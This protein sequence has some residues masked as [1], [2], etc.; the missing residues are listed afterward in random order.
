MN[1]RTSARLAWGGSLLA[2]AALALVLPLAVP[3]PWAVLAVLAVAAGLFLAADRTGKPDRATPAP[4]STQEKPAAATEPAALAPAPLPPVPPPQ[5]DL[6]GPRVRALED[7]SWSLHKAVITRIRSL[8]TP[9]SNSLLGIKNDL[10]GLLAKSGQLE[11]SF[12]NDTQG[13]HQTVARFEAQSATIRTF[14]GEMDRSV[15]QFELSSQE[16]GARLG[17]IAQAIQQI[18]DVAE[19]IKVLSINASI[20]AA[21]AGQ[22][23]AGFKVISQEVRRLAEDTNQF[24]DQADLTISEAIAEIQAQFQRFIVQ[25]QGRAQEIH[26]IRSTTQELEAFLKN[27]FSM[28]EGIFQDYDGFVGSLEADLDQISPT[29]QQAEIGTQQVEN[30]WKGI[31]E[32]IAAEWEGEADAAQGLPPEEV[33]KLL[34]VFSRH[35]TTPLE[36]EVVDDWARKAG[37]ALSSNKKQDEDITLF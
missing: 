14:A 5:T 34:Q 18:N 19:R 2:T 10:R 30:T 33:L 22:Q 8:L 17:S 13:L 16:M 20:E 31:R 21:R 3:L 27:L 28:I 37:V 26:Q 24:S 9:L 23:G 4:L 1:R 35:L 36:A 7:I 11:A 12:R 29:L 25:Y 32:F 15:Q 6:S